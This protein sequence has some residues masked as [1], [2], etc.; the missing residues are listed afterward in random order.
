M[1]RIIEKVG[2]TYAL[3]R[4]KTIYKLSEIIKFRAKIFIK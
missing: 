2:K 1:A 3:S 4:P